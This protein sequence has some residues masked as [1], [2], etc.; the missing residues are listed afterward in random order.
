MHKGKLPVSSKDEPLPIKEEER[1]ESELRKAIETE[2]FERA[3]DLRDKLK[4]IRESHLV[5]K[6]EE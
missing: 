2:D 6:D 4:A 3:A 1:L 5:S